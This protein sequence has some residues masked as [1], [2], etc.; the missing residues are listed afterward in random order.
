MDVGLGELLLILALALIVLGP[1]RLP[2]VGAAL[3]RALYEFR[4]ATAEATGALLGAPPGASLPP[5]PPP[6]SGRPCVACGAFVRDGHRF[7]AVCGGDQE[8]D[9]FRDAPGRVDARPA[10]APA[11]AA[12]A[13]SDATVGTS[14]AAPAIFAGE[15]GWA[16]AAV[17]FAQ[18]PRPEDARPSLP[19]SGDVPS[20]TTSAARPAGADA[21]ADAGGGPGGADDGPPGEPSPTR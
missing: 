1:Q 6:P 13:L 12:T 21:A 8:A 2:E 11:A 18:E 9:L 10:S 16:D 5:P 19:D 17:P 4:R 3:G 7:C 14:G 15:P 20:E